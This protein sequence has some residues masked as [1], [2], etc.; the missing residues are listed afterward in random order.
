MP[1]NERSLLAPMIAHGL[2]DFFAFLVIAVDWRKR[3]QH[4]DAKQTAAEQSDTE[5]QAS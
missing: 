3:Q 1:P 5:P 2:Y 4:R